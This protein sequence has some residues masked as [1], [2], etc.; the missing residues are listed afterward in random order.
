MFFLGGQLLAANRGAWI[1]HNKNNQKIISPIL[2]EIILIFFLQDR[3]YPDVAPMDEK[4]EHIYQ[5][6]IKAQKG[7]CLGG[8][9]YRIII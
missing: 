4:T 2:E 1:W 6:D 3:F 8:L 5:P 9:L 7:F